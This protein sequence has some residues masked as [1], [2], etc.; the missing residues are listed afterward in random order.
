MPAYLLIMSA[1][2]LYK[3]EQVGRF[4]QGVEL[5]YMTIGLEVQY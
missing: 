3:R 5:L 1:Y 2:Q 4:I